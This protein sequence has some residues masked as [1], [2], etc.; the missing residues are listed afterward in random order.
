[1]WYLL[2][3]IPLV[4]LI[5]F[6][7]DF[8]LLPG[9]SLSDITISHFPNLLYIQHSLRA[10]QGIPLW[11][12]AILSGY[13]FVADPL[14]GLH[15]PPGWLALFF[16]LP[17]GINLT[18]ALHLVFGAFGMYLFLKAEG[19]RSQ[20]AAI[21]GLAFALLPKLIGHYAAGHLSLLYAI[22]WTPWLLLA[23]K[24]W[25]ENAGSH[26]LWRA[27]GVVL[28]LIFLADPRWVLYSGGLWLAYS[29]KIRIH[30]W[31]SLKQAGRHVFHLILQAVLALGI[32]AALLLPLVQFT[33]LSTRA[34]MTAADVLELSMPWSGLIN[35]FFP[36]SGGNVEWISYTGAVP[37]ALVLVGIASKNL[38]KG[39]RFWL[40]L[41]F[42]SLILSLGS[43]I[44]GMAYLTS[45]PGLSLL[46][47][48]A[49]WLFIALICLVVA[50]GKILE[51][52]LKLEPGKR[53]M[54]LLAL[55]GVGTAMLIFTTG[56]SLLSGKIVNELLLATIGLLLATVVIVLFSRSRW[57]A[58][59]FSHLLLGVLLINLLGFG[60]THLE[61]KPAGEIV[62]QGAGVTAILK[63]KPGHFRVYSPS[64]SLPQQTAALHG[65]ELADGVDPLQLSVYWSFMQAATGVPSNGY[66]VT[67]PDF[68]TGEPSTD[69]L[70]FVPDAYQLGLLN[71]CFVVSEFDLA[72]D[73]L[74]LI[75]QVGTTRIYEN[76]L[77]QPRAWVDLGYGETR[78]V[79][80]LEYTPN[81]ITLQ[82]EGPGPLVLSEVV[83]PGWQVLVD[84]EPAAIQPYQG[85]LRSV[86]LE[87]G[88]HKIQ[89]DFKPVLAYLG[90][91]ITGGTFVILL[92]LFILGKIHSRS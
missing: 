9:T 31:L 30:E 70:A 72:V 90:I 1:M 87:A 34:S 81:S 56:G 69:N 86:E 73:G 26:S 5:P 85:L 43:G 91:G 37:L 83:Y 55:I 78:A 32:S 38:G 28:G 13:P 51:E 6:W 16:P 2:C 45:L 80:V 77:C 92:I 4:L 14:S 25:K 8:I 15:Y 58:S 63:S 35:L 33:G 74:S 36:I 42:G 71:V 53:K 61:G 22:S 59:T 89:F 88:S 3:L 17:F 65:I 10:G 21:S 75:N 48:P 18:A 7:G 20:A 64:Y 27:P 47:I 40:W 50:G 62:S 68:A 24:R 41:A 52:V 66:S 23:E 12:N 54:N 79:D 11:S 60:W 39:S 46:R 44:P 82:A 19:L 29:L 67:L 76:C 57:S 49:R 84:G